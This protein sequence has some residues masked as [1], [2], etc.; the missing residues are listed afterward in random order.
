MLNIPVTYGLAIRIVNDFSARSVMRLVIVSAYEKVK[1]LQHV[2]RTKA[3]LIFRLVYEIPKVTRLLAAAL[4]CAQPDPEIKHRKMRPVSVFHADA[5]TSIV[6]REK[7][8]CFC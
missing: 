7:A 5:G 3:D 2:R 1:A 8:G 4:F 6:E